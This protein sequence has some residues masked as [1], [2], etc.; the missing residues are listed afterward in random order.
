M[1][2]Q[3]Y[4]G[5]GGALLQRNVGGRTA[6]C[7]GMVQVPLLPVCQTG[8]GAKNGGPA[9]YCSYFSVVSLVWAST[10]ATSCV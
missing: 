3:R 2:S 5:G 10:Q 1:P 4:D 7:S 9:T 8:K 6:A